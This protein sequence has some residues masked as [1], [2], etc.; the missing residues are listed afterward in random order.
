VICC[1]GY[2]F[3]FVEN[4]AFAYV[5]KCVRL[6]ILHLSIDLTLFTLKETFMQIYFMYE[7]VQIT[8]DAVSVSL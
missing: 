7:A 6:N 2:T 3:L 1:V 4:I 5:I 8:C